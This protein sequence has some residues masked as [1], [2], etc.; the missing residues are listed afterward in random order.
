MPFR[1]RGLSAFV[2]RR[3]ELVRLTVFS[4]PDCCAHLQR[5]AG[6]GF[7]RSLCPVSPLTVAAC[8]PVSEKEGSQCGPR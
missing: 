3:P 5:A 8:S 6:F 1:N 2:V 7:S 4:F